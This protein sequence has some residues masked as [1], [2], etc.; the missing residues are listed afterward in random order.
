MSDVLDTREVD[1]RTVWEIITEVEL[2]PGGGFPRYRMLGP[3]ANALR[4]AVA[5]AISDGTLGSQL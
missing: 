3:E 4:M 1:F 5:E 2:R